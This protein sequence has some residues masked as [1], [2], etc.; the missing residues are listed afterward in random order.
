MPSVSPT[1]A[2]AARYFTAKA[3]VIASIIF[4]ATRHFG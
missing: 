2:M 4:I 3:A 1:P